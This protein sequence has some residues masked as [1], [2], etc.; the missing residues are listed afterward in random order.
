MFEPSIGVGYADAL[1]RL[2]RLAPERLDNHDS[3]R[4]R[5][6][7]DRDSKCWMAVFGLGDE[8]AHPGA[9]KTPGLL[10][11][12]VTSVVLAGGFPH[13]GELVESRRARGELA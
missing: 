6:N 10:S 4:G 9:A 12:S 7:S 1:R 13:C 8:I 11:L 3:V 2:P 5:S